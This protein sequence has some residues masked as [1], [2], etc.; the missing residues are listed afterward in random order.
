M[1]PISQKYQQA[2]QR[3]LNHIEAV[4]EAFRQQCQK[5]KDET[6]AKIAALDKNAPDFLEK[7]NHLKLNLKDNLQKVLTEMELE[8]KRSF[9]IGLLELEEIYHQ[10]EL[11]GIKKLEQEILAL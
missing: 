8:L 1:D 5:L 4:G 2:A 11:V 10:K 3:Q 6:E 7:S 9:G